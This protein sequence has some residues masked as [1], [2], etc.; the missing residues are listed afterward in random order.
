MRQRGRKRP[1][2]PPRLDD[3]ETRRAAAVE[4]IAGL[5]RTLAEDAEAAGTRIAELERALAAAQ[6]DAASLSARLD[7]M[8]TARLAA[9]QKIAALTEALAEAE[10]RAVTLCEQA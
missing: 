6:E 1:P 3:T 9:Q 4:E 2:S 5:Q 8:E 10:A 7:D